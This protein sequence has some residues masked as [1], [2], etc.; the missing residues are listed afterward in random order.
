MPDATSK[1]LQCVIVS[2]ETTVLDRSV[3]FVAVP[4]YDGELG[5]LPGRAPLVARLGYGELRTTDAGET[6]SYF[7]DGG[8][9]QVR[10]D[11][12]SILTSRAIRASAI[13]Q[14]GAQA[15]LDRANAQVPTTPEGFEAK[16]ISMAR[17]RAQLQI[18][19]RAAKS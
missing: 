16:V 3:D 10:N 19:G 8:F 9:L 13:D 18:A 12:V 5:I 1:K 15:A 6:T 17:A 2:P 7:I 4:L 14:A 11:V